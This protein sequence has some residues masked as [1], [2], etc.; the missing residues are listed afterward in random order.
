MSAFT[1]NLTRRHLIGAALAL[2]SGMV[3]GCGSRPSVGQQRT[4]T[5]PRLSSLRQAAITVYR[6]PSCGCC[7]AWAK[8][9]REA[10]FA[11]SVIASPDMP[12][13]KRKHGVP[14]QL[15]SCHTS[16]AGGYTIEGHVPLE[17]VKRLLKERP[18]GIKGISVPGMPRGAP[19]MET[20][21]G[22]KDR[23]QVI[24]FDGAGKLS[25]YRKV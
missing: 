20:A 1:G 21:D 7:G 24:A 9:A 11:V 13:I 14:A 6:D 17:D 3:A 19:G 22:S 5:G 8:A 2:G 15:E 18:K 10:G 4:E 23:F 12:A 25:L 16:I